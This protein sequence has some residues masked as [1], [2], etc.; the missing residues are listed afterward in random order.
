MAENQ[1]NIIR[2]LIAGAGAALLLFNLPDPISLSV[3][4]APLLIAFA[5]TGLAV[6][7][8]VALVT[9]EL[10]LAHGIGM[11]ACLSLPAMAQDGALWAVGVGALL[12]E[13]AALGWRATQRFRGQA[14][15]A[16]TPSALA[17]LGVGVARAVISL[18]AASLTYQAIGGALPFRTI[19]SETLL[20]LIPFTLVYVGVN[21]VLFLFDVRVLNPRP[22]AAS[23]AVEGRWHSSAGGAVE[24]IAA[25]ILPTPFAILAADA[26]AQL[27]RTAFVL[28]IAALMLVILFMY[29]I[30]HARLRLRRR[31]EELESLASM[32]ETLQ[33]TTELQPL[34]RSIKGHVRALMEVSDVEIALR[35]PRVP[36]LDSL[37]P[38]GHS[39]IAHVQTTGAP[40]LISSRVRMSA[41][42]IGMEVPADV[43]SWLGVP[44]MSGGA[45]LG[46]LAVVSRT[47]ARL[48][49]R[50]DARRL[51]IIAAGASVALENARRQEEQTARVQQLATLNNILALLS[52][53]LSPE[54]VLD[55][56][57]TSA[58]A[59]SGASAVTV[60]L[61]WDD[62]AASPL[63]V[64]CA[65]FSAELIAQPPT[66]LLIGS[67]PAG[68]LNEQPPLVVADVT[69]DVRTVH[70]REKMAREHKRGWI[71]LPLVVGAISRGIIGL[72]FDDPPSLSPE[73]V[74]LLR[75][76]AN[77]AAQAI[78]NA[79][80]FA[81]TD[82]ALE[83]RVGQL[84]A[85]AGIGQEL[86]ALINLT[87]ICEVVVRHALDAVLPRMGVS[88]AG[89][90]AL[91]SERT[92]HVE[93]W[94]ARGYPD[95]TF[96]DVDAAVRGAW[97][98]VGRDVNPILDS[99]AGD[100]P[101]PNALL[102]S[103]RA[104]ILTPIRRGELWLGV[105]ALETDRADA[106]TLEDSQFVGQ[107]A[108]Q[109]VIAIDNARLFRRIAEALDRLQVILNAMDEAILLIDADGL[110]ALANPRVSILGL[111]ADDLIGRAVDNLTNAPDITGNLGFVARD[112]LQRLVA[113]LRGTW[114]DRPSFKYTRIGEMGDELT[115][116]RQTIPV[117]DDEGH[118][119][120]VMLVFHDES[121]AAQLAQARDD[122]SRMIV[123]DLRGP[124]TA[125]TTGLSILTSTIPSESPYRE[126]VET[127][128]ESSRR[129]IRKLLGRVNALMDVA[130]MESG[131]MTLD[132]QP[133]DL[134]TLIDSVC[135]ELSP[136][137]HELNIKIEPDLPDDLPSLPIDADKVERL[138][139]NLIDNALKF[140]PLDS[141]IIV[142][143]RMPGEG[144]SLDGSPGFAR[145][146]VIDSGPG[147]P[148]EE[149]PRL[150][151]RFAQIKGRKGRRRGT[152]LGLAFCRL[153]SEA[154]GGRIW[155]E[156]NP[157]GGSVFVFTLPISPVG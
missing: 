118:A 77:Q 62:R 83:R 154:H 99:S 70:L 9:G 19:N 130:R 63:L 110:I 54:G 46:A 82:E 41:A 109:A 125:I 147:I 100:V 88:A 21:A 31:M 5:L 127:T 102:P 58:S 85:L 101:P 92:G 124:L 8:N 97:K 52:G 152:G 49:D 129:S 123:H 145:V 66:P 80:L 106:F 115:I 84:L 105:L 121:E 86:T 133:T 17:S 156:D 60:Y 128:S 33:S 153:V 44:L 40:L 64:R 107:L 150:F 75:T 39:L 74:E 35:Q 137:A 11:V 122:F 67:A 28:L 6:V 120:G 116:L 14:L 20:P 140:S 112:E 142:R 69:T 61:G 38:N 96:A 72:Y 7:F 131:H 143:A 73:S 26:Y 16:F 90:I 111:S 27:S 119:M 23:P 79:R 132:L 78:E 155:I 10:S 144:N 45:S 3:Y 91:I 113:D 104:L 94:A 2:W 53:T 126:V 108:T 136:L 47:S 34:L 1:R 157:D 59:L 135:I 148:N 43:V 50:D 32:S 12:G 56:V 139:L 87:T 22:K 4:A 146:E 103:S 15:V 13:S 51:T 114:T 95:D 65:G 149:K 37:A 98:A 29:G 141:T 71:E 89:F 138:L 81:I 30:S 42:Q 24:L 36:L 93:A 134:A 117:Y 48:F 18:Y 25:L 55:T 76:F 68:S 151:D 57:I